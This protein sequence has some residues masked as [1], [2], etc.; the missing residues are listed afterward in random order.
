MAFTPEYF[1]DGLGAVHSEHVRID[2]TAPTKPVVLTDVP[3]DEGQ[4]PEFRYL[5]MPLRVA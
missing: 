2:F 4:A 5:V 1:L 3:A